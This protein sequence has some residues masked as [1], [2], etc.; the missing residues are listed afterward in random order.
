MT[1]E[2][3]QASPPVSTQVG[4]AGDT[5]QSPAAVSP[6]D[7]PPAAPRGVDA[8]IIRRAWR[9]PHS[10]AWFIAAAVVAVIMLWVLGDQT[11]RWLTE[12]TLIKQGLVVSALVAEANGIPRE[13]FQPKDSEATLVFTHE[14]R[15]YKVAGRLYG[16]TEPIV[17]KKNVDI[18]I[19]PANPLRWTYRS[20]PV[21][22]VQ[23]LVVGLALLPAAAVLVGI[24][25][26]LRRRLI[27]TWRDGNATEA[28]VLETGNSPI[29]PLSRTVRCVDIHSSERRPINVFVP[30]GR[31]VAKGD[32]I[33][34]LV[35]KSG[36][37]VAAATF[38]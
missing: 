34:L 21:P 37:P 9:D 7:A 25:M 28:L 5:A 20:E 27:S 13:S 17:V 14:G 30:R 33:W 11:L 2:P 8:T 18:R 22:L 38:Q 31:R 6:A 19:D 32:V 23:E 36:R 12:R 1:A 26:W 10:R 16:R 29:A 15:E 3:S 4:A 24:G 35:P